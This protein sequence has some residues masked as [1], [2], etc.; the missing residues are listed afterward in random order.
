MKTKKPRRPL[1]DQCDDQKRVRD[2]LRSTGLRPTRQRLLVGMI[3]LLSRKHFNV[4]L[5]TANEDVKAAQVSLASLYNIL[6]DFERVGLLKRLVV[7]SRSVYYDSE[8]SEHH[9]IF[10]EDVGILVDAPGLSVTVGG[11]DI[12]QPDRQIVGIDVVVRM[13]R[14]APISS[15]TSPEG[16]A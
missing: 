11:P 15:E 12:L 10:D 8:L 7:D 4:A 1:V 9:H 13:R 16:Q 6:N 2:I 5:L 3:T 14:L